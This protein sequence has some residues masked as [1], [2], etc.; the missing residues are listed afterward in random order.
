MLVESGACKTVYISIK[1]YDA[2]V[3]R[4]AKFLL[5]QR[6]TMVSLI[7][8]LTASYC[9]IKL[10]TLFNLFDLYSHHFDSCFHLVKCSRYLIEPPVFDH[11]KDDFIEPLH[12]TVFK[13]NDFY[14]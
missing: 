11:H 13:I 10:F 1:V 7:M 5:V 4:L 12:K 14:F 8:F 9:Y 3:M 6:L 2:L